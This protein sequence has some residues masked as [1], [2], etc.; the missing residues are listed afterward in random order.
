[1]DDV[2]A[3][4]IGNVIGYVSIALFISF[5][6]AVLINEFLNRKRK[7]EEHA[8]NVKD[9]NESEIPEEPK[10]KKVFVVIYSAFTRRVVSYSCKIPNDKPYIEPYLP[11]YQWFY[12]T[13]LPV[14]RMFYEGGMA[15]LVRGFIERI[16]I[17]TEDPDPN[18]RR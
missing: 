7:K 12:C 14:Y 5:I 6:I 18:K 17:T 11:V 3:N 9:I 16:D 8:D 4:L 1:M 13:D 10:E 2:T 15:L